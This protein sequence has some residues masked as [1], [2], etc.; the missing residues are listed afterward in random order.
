[1]LQNNNINKE[2]RATN[3]AVCCAVLCC[4]VL[5]I[6]MYSL[7]LFAPVHVR[8]QFVAGFVW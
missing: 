8:R 5:P 6:G 7:T 4:A 3:A 2:T 1:M